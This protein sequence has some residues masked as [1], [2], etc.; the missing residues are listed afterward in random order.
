MRQTTAK[1]AGAHHVGLTVPDLTAANRFFTD[2]LG[3]SQVGEAPDY[4]AVFLS[5]GSIMITLWQAKDPANAAVF[6]R[7][8]NI[9]LHH[10]ALRVADNAALDTLHAELA[11]R[12]DVSIEFAP[13]QLGNMPV[14]HMICGIPGD[15][16]LEFIAA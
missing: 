2:A 8:H 7:H 10:L 6:D 14:R 16:R 13:E 12:D 5:D 1:T 4:P 11:A 3:Y 15:I 9:G